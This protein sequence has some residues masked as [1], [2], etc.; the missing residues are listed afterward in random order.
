M[1]SLLER[2]TMSTSR[3]FLF[4]LTFWGDSGAAVNW[5][6]FLGGFL[7]DSL[8]AVTCLS[9]W[10]LAALLLHKAFHYATRY[11][12]LRHDAGA[13]WPASG[14]H[15]PNKGTPRP[16]SWP[17][18][19]RLQRG[20][21]HGFKALDP[22]ELQDLREHCDPSTGFRACRPQ[23]RIPERFLSSRALAKCS[24]DVLPCVLL[25]LLGTCFP[26]TL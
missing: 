18:S 10:V 6:L 23:V 8:S 12:Q 2:L 24:S 5:H 25:A 9:P 22:R 14:L 11:M 3:C 16:G 21:C 4:V 17:Q 26:R 15:L 19:L 20:W 13:H 7:R 1:C